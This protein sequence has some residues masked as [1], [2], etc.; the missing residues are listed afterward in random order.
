MLSR[1]V[2]KFTLNN[3]F[4]QSPIIDEKEYRKVYHIWALRYLLFT[5]N[6]LAKHNQKK[7]F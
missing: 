2:C 1:F 3:F 4:F 5:L 6:Y 7:F